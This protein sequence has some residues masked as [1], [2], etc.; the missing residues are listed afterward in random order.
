MIY[1]RRFITNLLELNA[2]I[3]ASQE[4]WAS[5]DTESTGLHLK[6]DKPFLFTLT[7][8][9]TS[10]AVD[11]RQHSPVIFSALIMDALSKFK[12]L[13]GHNVKFDLHMLVNY[14]VHYRY[15]NLTDTMILARLGLDTDE[16]LTLKLKALAKR[17]IGK[18]RGNDEKLV[19]A[20]IRRLKQTS[21]HAE[22]TYDVVFDHRDY[23]KIMLDYAMNDTEIT[24]ELAHKLYA[25][26][27]ERGHEN[28]FE[29]ENK[30][31]LPL[32]DMERVG[33][34][35]DREYLM[36]SHN[37]VNNYIQKLY[38]ELNSILQSTYTVNQHVMLKKTLLKLWHIHVDSLDDKALMLIQNGKVAFVPEM[39]DWANRLMHYENGTFA[40]EEIR[41]MSKKEFSDADPY[42][43]LWEAPKVILRQEVFIPVYAEAP[44]EAKRAAKLISMLRTLEKWLSTYIVRMYELS[45][46]DGRAYTQVNAN[47]AVTGRLSSDFQQFPRDPLT[48]EDGEVLF[49]PRRMV[50]TTGGDYEMTAYLDYSQVELR[51]QANYT[52]LMSGGDLNM[53]RAYMP[54]LCHDENGVKFDPLVHKSEIRTKKWYTDEGNEE[55]KEVDLHGATAHQAF[56]EVPMDSPEFKPIRNLGKSTNFAKNYGATLNALMEQFGYTY[57]VAKALDGGYYKAFPKVLDYQ[58]TVKQV[59]YKRGYVK[60]MYGRRYYMQDKRFVYRLYNYLV[61]GTCADM[62]K[63]KMREVYDFLRPYKSRFQMNIHDE[64]SFEI[65]NGEEFIIP[66]IKAIM[67]DT[68]NIVIPIVAE[69]EVTTTNWSEKHKDDKIL[70]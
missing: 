64:M 33:L 1:T 43:M 5:F 12:Y 19:K 65:Y 39:P 16:T 30:I 54:H 13:V 55:W 47:S 18:E 41:E 9:K 69:V 23:S 37:K 26:M 46:F 7:F 49:I 52:Y 35:I 62:L 58:K 17:Y 61:Q 14:G 57:D 56:P 42:G 59:F 10:F 25:Q 38:S 60:D 51:V 24:L 31:I 53:C 29:I 70:H 27:I 2:I 11:L 8:G 50:L 45:E 44:K 67:E 68:P 15:D 6:K 32:F 34:R 36:E 28:V 4:E 40:F 3:L 66:K 22:I 48:T 20:A 21:A 63:V